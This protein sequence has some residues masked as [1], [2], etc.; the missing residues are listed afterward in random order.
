MSKVFVTGFRPYSPLTWFRGNPSQVVAER[1][2]E[3]YTA[4]AQVEIL[5]AA[6]TCL[7]QIESLGKN[8][9]L[10]GVLM[11]G[12]A[13]QFA[14]VSAGAGRSQ[15]GRWAPPR[16]EEQDRVQ[17]SRGRSL[18][19]SCTSTCSAPRRQVQTASRFF[20]KSA[21]SGSIASAIARF[22]RY[23]ILTPRHER[24]TPQPSLKIDC[25]RSVTTVGA[26]VETSD[27]RS[28]FADNRAH[29]TIG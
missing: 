3:R 14:S 13:V 7:T 12:A 1:L 28:I 11:L 27:A 21:H 25:A 16:C 8:Q 17:R 10:A 26:P 6:P 2:G 18:A 19:S 24:F 15:Q 20:E 29:V 23:A 4:D 22:A 9:A 5:A